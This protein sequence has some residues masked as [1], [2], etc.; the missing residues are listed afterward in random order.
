MNF[1]KEALWILKELNRNNHEAYL[2]GGC[3]RD[4]LLKLENHDIDITTSAF[5]DEIRQ[6]FQ[7]YPIL[8]TG[9]KHGTLTLILDKVP[10][11]ITTY[12]I[13]KDYIDHRRPA[14]VSFT[15][16][17]N[18]DLNRRDF[19]INALCWHP[20]KGLID[21]NHGIEDLNHKLIRC[22]GN[23]DKRFDEDALRILRAMRFASTLSFSIDPQTEVSMFKKKELLKFISTERINQEFSKLLKGKNA[24]FILDQ[25]TDILAV[26]IPEIAELKESSLPSFKEMI[27]S[28]RQSPDVLTLRLALILKAIYPDS[29]ASSKKFLSRLKYSNQ[30]IKRVTL[31][32]TL[33]KMPIES[34]ID[35]KKILSICQ[36]DSILTEFLSLKQ[37]LSL[38]FPRNTVLN[39][40]EEFKKNQ[41]CLTLEDCCINGNDC[42]NLQIQK[43]E[44]KSVLNTILNEIIEEKIPNERESCLNRAKELAHLK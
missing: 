38:Q 18:E 42:L 8:E 44:I 20:T 33:E 9:I 43:K 23:P 32:L 16:N 35:I 25:Y 14:S 39:I 10:Y 26:F 7:D 29:I 17:L 40:I 11:E 21:F 12:R 27:A 36:D 34:R 30:T 22:I 1:K 5:P 6:C 15:R 19:S 24:P 41:E 3:V 13:E 31:L 28:L 37:T 2:V 4:A